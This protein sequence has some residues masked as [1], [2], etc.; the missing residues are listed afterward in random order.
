M[1]KLKKYYVC[2]DEKK[3]GTQWGYYTIVLAENQNEIKKLV[4]DRQNERRLKG[5]PH[6]FHVHTIRFSDALGD[7]DFRCRELLKLTG[8]TLGKH[9]ED[10]GYGVK[11]IE[12][13]NPYFNRWENLG[14]VVDPESQ[15][16]YT[17]EVDPFTGK[18]RHCGFGKGCFWTE[19]R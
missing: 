14:Y 19:W 16:G 6:M 4:C 9:L 8:T 7:R 10:F 11:R 5:L 3:G 12:K 18:S 13:L 2:W 15:Y 17:V 1:A